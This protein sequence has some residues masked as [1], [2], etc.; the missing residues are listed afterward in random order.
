[1]DYNIYKSYESDDGTEYINDCNSCAQKELKGSGNIRVQSLELF[2]II[3]LYIF[4]ILIRN[5]I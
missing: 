3:M 2:R 4:L 1:M 5:M